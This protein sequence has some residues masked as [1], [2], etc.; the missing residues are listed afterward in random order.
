VSTQ[1]EYI[2]STNVSGDQAKDQEKTLTKKREEGPPFS[3]D[4]STTN[5]VG[6]QSSTE[7]GS[8]I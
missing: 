8:P 5:A 1:K 2:P 3:P 7:I 4:K 6:K